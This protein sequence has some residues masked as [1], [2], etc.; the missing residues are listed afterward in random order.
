MTK[1][2]EEEKPER[3]SRK[4]F[5]SLQKVSLTDK[6][7]LEHGTKLAELHQ[8]LATIE[9]ELDT[10]KSQFK[11]KIAAVET[12]IGRE[13]CLVRDRFEY[14]NVTCERVIDY[15]AELVTETRL[16]TGEIINKRDLTE[17]ERQ[18]EIDRVV[19]VDFA[20]QSGK[21]A[22]QSQDKVLTPPPPSTTADEV[23]Q[24]KEIIL[25]TRRASVSSIQRRMKIG[26]TAAAR[27]MDALEEIGFVGPA[28][29][30]EPREILQL[31]VKE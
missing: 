15:A 26:Y 23:N 7:L 19:D 28:N 11:S 8:E 4:K 1:K 20:A 16:D 9:N 21:A 30:D 22:G 13:V 3:I 24:A 27:I 18:M 6:E 2:K 17:G 10:I 31:P 25:E 29:G 12:N 5:D 14:R